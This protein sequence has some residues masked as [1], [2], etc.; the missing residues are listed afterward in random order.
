MVSP[1]S[2][3]LNGQVFQALM[4]LLHQS[5]DGNHHQQQQQQQY[6]VTWLLGY[7]VS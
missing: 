2:Q 3:I 5:L 4:T 6:F 7:L 1:F